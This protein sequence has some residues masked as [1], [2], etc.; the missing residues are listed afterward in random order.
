MVLSRNMLKVKKYTQN[1]GECAICAVA[2]LSHF[3]KKEIN[4][5]YVKNLIEKRARKQGLWTTEMG[6]LLNILGFN[7]IKL[8]TANLNMIDFSWSNFSKPKIIKKIKRLSQYYKRINHEFSDMMSHV[9]Q[10]LTDKE[11]DNSIV[12]DHDFPVHIK[13]C[14]DRGI[15]VIATINAT[16]L[17]KLPKG[18][19]AGVYNNKELDIKGTAQEHA[20]VIRGYDSKNVYIVDSDNG[21][22]TQF[23]KYRTGYYKLTWNKFL[24]GT[25]NGDLLYAE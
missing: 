11:N 15:P 13:R 25:Q 24:I 3:Y 14:I 7:S 22:D 10:W 17:F 12:I 4:D 9:H 8:V 5:E 6:E 18:P 19:V 23:K 20:V 21:P 1:E 2:S 16:V